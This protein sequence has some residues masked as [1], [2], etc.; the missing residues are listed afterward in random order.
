MLDFLGFGIE[1]LNRLGVACNFLVHDL[2][3]VI[4]LLKL[5]EG[6]SRDIDAF[7]SRSADLLSVV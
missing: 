7:G 5:A 2:Y 4:G 6:L 1:R 3:A